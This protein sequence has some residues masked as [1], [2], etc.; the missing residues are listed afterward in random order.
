MEP[1]PTTEQKAWFSSH[2]VVLTPIVV[3]VLYT[4]QQCSLKK[5][6]MG[7]LE[8]QAKP[9]LH[10]IMTVFCVHLVIDQPQTGPG[11]RSVREGGKA[12]HHVQNHTLLGQ[13]PPA[14]QA[15]LRVG[16]AF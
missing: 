6:C 3:G 10:D 15:D 9:A 14:S 4:L 1:L 2:I 13:T 11:V 5:E 12:V 7:P 8:Y 16:P